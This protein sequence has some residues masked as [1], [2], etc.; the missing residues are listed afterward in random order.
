MT[1]KARDLLEAHEKIVK[2][3][4]EIEQD[5]VEIDG[6]YYWSIVRERLYD[7]AKAPDEDELTIGQLS[8]DR[9]WIR[10]IMEEDGPIV[11]YSL[12]WLSTLLRAY[13]ERVVG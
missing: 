11:G 3:L 9:E 6:D 7:V 4:E 5:E 10:G 8:E 12:V 1:L 13:G 2:H